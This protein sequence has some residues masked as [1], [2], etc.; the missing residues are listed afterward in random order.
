M[1]FLLMMIL[2][3]GAAELWG[4]IRALQVMLVSSLVVF[5]RPVNLTLFLIICVKFS[6]FDLFDGSGFY[7]ENLSFVETQPLNDSFEFYGIET[8]I[9]LINSGSYFVMQLIIVI[10]VLINCSLNRLAK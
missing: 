3:V 5:M 6:G 10:Q 9:M 1:A 2:S 8:K 7:E 4:S